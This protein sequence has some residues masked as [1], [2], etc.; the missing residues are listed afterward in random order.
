MRWRSPRRSR[1]W[2]RSGA[3]DFLWFGQKG[4]GLDES[5]VGPMVAE[6]LDLPHVANVVKLEIGEGKVTAHREIEGAHEV[7]ECALPSS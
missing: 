7:V 2:R 6:L 3:C 5:L 1:R 4:V